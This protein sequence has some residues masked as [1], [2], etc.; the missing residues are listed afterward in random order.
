MLRLV[1][2]FLLA[3]SRASILF[4]VL[5]LLLLALVAARFLFLSSR[6]TGKGRGKARPSSTKGKKII[7]G[8]YRIVD[9]DGSPK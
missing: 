5:P 7:D 3:L 4:R 1:A 6:V 2:P 9:D 8:S